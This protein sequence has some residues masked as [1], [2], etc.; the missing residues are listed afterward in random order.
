MKDA[1]DKYTIWYIEDDELDIDLFEV[2]FG[3][4]F[5]IKSVC[6]SVEM[7]E[8]LNYALKNCD[9]IV[10]DYNFRGDGINYSA[11]NIEK[12]MA[13]E[14]PDFPFLVLT[15]YYYKDTIAKFFRPEIVFPKPDEK[16]ETVA[17]ESAE[18][19][20]IDV[21]SQ[22]M[23]TKIE[24][25]KTSL[26]QKEKRLKE[27]IKEF[28]RKKGELTQAEFIE[29]KNLQADLQRL[30]VATLVG[31]YLDNFSELKTLVGI[32]DKITKLLERE[33]NAS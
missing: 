16:K 7:E 9:M 21:L 12:Y 13:Q 1:A 6:P 31:P 33:Q 26:D 8:Q 25:F 20:L 24:N 17:R 23:H 11:E 10:T 5:L 22:T 2:Q 15:N 28:D 32:H 29:A 14:A 30:G 3:D 4:K 19:S 27:L 18:T